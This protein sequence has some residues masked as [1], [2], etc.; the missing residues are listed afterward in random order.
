[1]RSLTRATALVSLLFL[2]CEA[3]AQPPAGP[4]WGELQVHLRGAPIARGRPA[5][6][7][8]HGFGAPGDDL[9]GLAEGLRLQGVTLV[10]PEAP[11]DLGNGGR[12]WFPI[13]ANWRQRR[14]REDLS[15]LTPPGADVARRKIG[16]VI[17]ELR[18]LG[19]GPIVLG[20]FSQGGMMA[21]DVGLR[22]DDVAAIA[23]LSGM[24]LMREQWR[25]GE[26]RPVLVA[27]GRRDS[28]V[29]FAEGEK[30]RD[31]VGEVGHDLTWVAHEG[32]HTIPMRVREALAAFVREVL[33]G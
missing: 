23:S 5:L 16:R 33:A 4:D 15:A 14:M 8:L 24:L 25:R 13:P 19:A 26:T 2:S 21:L 7:L 12:A 27:H 6:L 18:R 10:V 22:R 20:G 9:V 29:P 1:V 17:D 30:L 11:I 28:L 3:R 31:F 32:D